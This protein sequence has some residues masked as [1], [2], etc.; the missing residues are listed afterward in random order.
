M[1]KVKKSARFVDFT[2]PT[3][4]KFGRLAWR[5]F[6]NAD[7]PGPCHWFWPG[8]KKWLRRAWWIFVRNPMH[9]FFW[10]VIGFT[11]KDRIVWGRNPQVVFLEGFNWHWGGPIDSWIRVPFISFQYTFEKRV[12]QMYIGW[13][14]AGNFGLACRVMKR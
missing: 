4:W 9:N 12:F 5:I 11:H 7:D 3:W 2:P 1:F 6:G 8:K 10:Y 14:Y 13:R